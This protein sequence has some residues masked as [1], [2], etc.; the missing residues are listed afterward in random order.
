MTKWRMFFPHRPARLNFLVPS[1][2]LVLAACSKEQRP[3]N[4]PIASIYDRNVTKIELVALVVN[5]PSRAKKV[6]HIYE[7]IAQLLEELRLIR[8]KI[9]ERLTQNLD[10]NTLDETQVRADVLELR[11]RSKQ[12]YH[13]YV[14]LQLELR[15]HLTKEEFARLDKVR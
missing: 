13:R 8:A 3:S 14:Q 1:L 2:F 12:S 15:K 9:S 6:R 5:E 7:D 4:H 11:K 10:A